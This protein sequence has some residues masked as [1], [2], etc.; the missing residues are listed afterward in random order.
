MQ[1]TKDALSLKAERLAQEIILSASNGRVVRVC[2]CG[3]SVV[4]VGL[5]C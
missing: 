2:W 4:C 3:L 1:G 5:I